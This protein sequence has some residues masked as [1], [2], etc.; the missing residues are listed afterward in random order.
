MKYYYIYSKYYSF[1]CLVK[2]TGADFQM[3]SLLLD[4]SPSLCPLPS[5]FLSGLE[6]DHIDPSL[7][8]LKCQRRKDLYT[9]KPDN[10]VNS[11]ALISAHL[12]TSF[13]SVARKEMANLS[14]SHL[15]K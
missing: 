11:A 15:S 6:P 14:F 3:E 10:G 2:Q 13:V 12:C 9:L 4:N 1:Y 7:P 8:L 5:T